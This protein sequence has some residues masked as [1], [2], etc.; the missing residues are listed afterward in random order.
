MEL[1]LGT[2]IITLIGRDIV[3]RNDAHV[4]LPKGWC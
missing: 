3:E 2:K 4:F 1:D